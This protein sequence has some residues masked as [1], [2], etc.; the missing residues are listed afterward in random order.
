MVS[1]Q[2]SSITKSSKIVYS[3]NFTITIVT[4]FIYLVPVEPNFLFQR[5]DNNSKNVLIVK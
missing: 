2:Q 1:Q 5:S 4:N 3:L